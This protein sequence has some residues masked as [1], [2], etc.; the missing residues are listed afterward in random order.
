M[1]AVRLIVVGAEMFPVRIDAHS[2]R[3]RTDWRSDYDH[4]SYQ[5]TALPDDVI[6]GVRAYMRRSGLYYGAWDFL[7]HG[8]D[9]LTCLECNPEGNYAWLE[10]VMPLQITEAIAGFLADPV[11]HPAG[12]RCHGPTPAAEPESQRIAS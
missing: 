11:T 6:A 12:D 8:D 10:E 3:A 4:L 2:D 7:G 9:T 1:F 5:L